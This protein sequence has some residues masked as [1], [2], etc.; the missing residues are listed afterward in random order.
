MATEDVGRQTQ[1]DEE[2][3]RE[4][5]DQFSTVNADAKDAV[6]QGAIE[7]RKEI[8][9]KRSS[10]GRGLI[11]LGKRLQATSRT[12]IRNVEGTLD[13]AAKR[14]DRSQYSAGKAVHDAS[15]T[16]DREYIVDL[17]TVGD[18]LMALRDANSVLT[19]SLR[20]NDQGT[21][22]RVVDKRITK[23]EKGA[24]KAIGKTIDFV[25]KRVT[26]GSE[27]TYETANKI[28][29]KTIQKGNKRLSKKQ[30]KI[31][32]KLQGKLRRFLMKSAK[33]YF[34]EIKRTGK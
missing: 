26:G 13:N 14:L 9:E 12:A 25:T 33:T 32:R 10:L 20:S 8:A 3:L 27:K 6:K 34:R 28:V 5:Q 7:L 30:M 24:D 23:I 4:E 11:K 1:E 2:A 22:L 17:E 21:K 19:R 15:E 18:D 31:I 16:S 29:G